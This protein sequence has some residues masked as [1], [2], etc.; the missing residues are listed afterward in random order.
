MSVRPKVLALLAIVA[1]GAGMLLAR[2][3]LNVPQPAP[4]LAKATLLSTP[5]ALPEF[6]L[7]DQDAQPF[8]HHRLEQH[9]SLVFFGFTRCPAVCPTTLTVLAQVQRQLQT[10]PATERPQ[11][12]LIS[13]DPTHDS[14]AQL[15]PYVNSFS[16]DFIGVTGGEDAIRSLAKS[17]GVSI[18]M[19]TMPGGEYT[20]DHSTAIFLVDPRGALRAVFSTPHAAD[21]IAADYRRIL[22]LR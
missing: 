9:W 11:V 18:T 19:Q 21:V 3:A 6:A 13:V 8:D 4:E 16:T 17:L 10:L 1:A 5:R 20:M 15:K 2:A 22:A 14:P 7:L 12:V